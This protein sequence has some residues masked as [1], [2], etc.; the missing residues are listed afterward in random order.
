MQINI[1]NLGTF[2]LFI[3]IYFIF[4]YLSPFGYEPDFWIRAP[5]YV[6]GTKDV[7][8]L[9][10][11]KIEFPIISDLRKLLDYES[12]CNTSSFDFKN[13]LIYG[14]KINNTLSIFQS[15]DHSSC[16]QKIFQILIRVSIVIIL[17]LPIW[18]MF[19]FKKYSYFFF[20]I[21]DS[22]LSYRAYSRNIDAVILSLF[23]PGMMY[24]L[25]VMAIE[26]FTL[27]IS[28]SLIFFS[29]SFLIILPIFL[30]ILIDFGNGF[31]LLGLII[32]AYLFLYIYQKLNYLFY[33][34]IILLTLST[35]YYFSTNLL[36]LLIN[37]PPFNF[38]PEILVNY[39]HSVENHNAVENTKDKYPLFVRPIIFFM[40]FIYWTPGNIKVILVYIIVFFFFLHFFIKYN[41]DMY[42]LSM[43]RNLSYA[44]YGFL[45][46]C[47]SHSL[48]VSCLI[49]IFI[50]PM[51]C[52]AKY[53]IFTLPF[54]VRT[55]LNYYS[56]SNILF[57]FLTIN[58]I[59]FSFLIFYRF[60]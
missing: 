8:S 21:I 35:T 30:I 39:F 50:L 38:L 6:L 17:T 36:S 47:L 37:N 55:M 56:K 23:F 24:Y 43:K 33:S 32:L 2:F 10:N 28:L 46:T 26:Q 11:F 42:L 18:L 41:F 14:S 59:I 53:Y 20:K 3:F 44:N 25:G 49:C 22:S 40:T 34:L 9:T 1:K 29:R 45:Y 5:D 7:W 19:I 4:R 27:L 12:F 13:H 52:N 57:F 60:L 54:I 51:Y 48:I 16:T 15:I 31:L 58:L